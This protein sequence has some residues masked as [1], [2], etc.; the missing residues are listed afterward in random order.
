MAKRNK[1]QTDATLDQEPSSNERA[2]PDVCGIMMP[3]S[4]TLGHGEGHWSDVLSLFHRAVRT[5]GLEPRNVWI[6]DSTDRI[7]KRILNN[8]FSAPIALCDISDLNPNVM[9]ELGMR[10]TSK[11]P[12]VVVVEKDGKIP[13]DIGDFEAITYP[14]DLN[15]IEMEKF[16]HRLEEQLK[17][18]L[19]AWK[20]DSYIPFLKDIGP[21]DFLEPDARAVPFERLMERQLDAI[22]ARLEKLDRRSEVR[23]RVPLYANSGSGA[24]AEGTT[25]A[26]IAGQGTL[27]PPMM[28]ARFIIENVDFDRAISILLDL[29][30]IRNVDVL[31]RG[32]RQGVV[33]ATA[34][35]TAPFDWLERTNGSLAGLKAEFA[36]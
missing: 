18:K 17:S 25:A 11:K 27:A 24:T 9:L 23:G 32:L 7:T 28:T 36:L 3:I 26:S 10:L 34:M 15:I 21:F 4:A 19:A 33:E 16:L 29:P 31:S 6:G 8:L 30:F 35:R 5:A 2:T 1:D 14:S 13:F 20:S 22:M 12:T